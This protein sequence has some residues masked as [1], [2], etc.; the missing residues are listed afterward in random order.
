MGQRGETKFIIL[1]GEWLKGC[2]MESKLTGS[3][4][5]RIRCHKS[6]EK[7]EVMRCVK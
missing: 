2:T 5:R 1:A 6:G 7:R 4:R 3:L